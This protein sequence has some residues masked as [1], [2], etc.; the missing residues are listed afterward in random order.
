VGLDHNPGVAFM[1]E[2]LGLGQRFTAPEAGIV[3]VFDEDS[4]QL[5]IDGG[6]AE[7]D[8]V[9]FLENTENRD[10]GDTLSLVRW[11]RTSSFSGGAV[12]LQ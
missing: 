4:G 11:D 1:A 2:S 7:G 8:N 10:S 3:K 6:E 9:L 12:S 5:L